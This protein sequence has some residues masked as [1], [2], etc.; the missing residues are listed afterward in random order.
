MT[1]TNDAAGSPSGAAGGSVR[2]EPTGSQE[3]LA[4]GA[5]QPS[6]R[7]FVE[8]GDLALE[9]GEVLPSVTMCFESWG[10]LDEAGDNAVLVLHALTGDSHVTGATGPDHPTPG[11]WDGLIGPGAPLDDGQFFVLAPNVLGGC[12]GT[13]GPSSIS[14]DGR[15]WGS[16]FPSL[17]TR[18]QVSAEHALARALGIRR[19]V[20]VIGGSMGGMRALEWG[21]T[22]P[23]EVDRVIAIAT[24]AAASADQ[25][26]WAAPQLAAIRLDPEFRAGDYYDGPG[27]I[28][29]M[30]VARQIAH[31]TYRSGFELDQRFGRQLQPGGGATSRPWFAVESYLAHHGEKLGRRFDPNSYLVLT[32]AMN[33]HDL[34]RGRGGVEAALQRINAAL[35][36]AVVDSDRLYTPAEGVRIAAAPAAGPLITMHS[37]HGHDGFLIEADQVAAVVR[38]A[39]GSGRARAVDE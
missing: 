25:I 16:R 15:P 19:V 12:R 5:G 32:E 37:D 6:G 10:R 24:T 21:V 30:A 31:I 9:S 28:G 17:T 27:P 11:W 33:A 38:D 14:P 2:G 34:G 29:G 36:V 7:R 20:A 18:D 1:R 23:D 26:A 8:I 4:Q 35:T 39:L 13:T 3:P 22:Y